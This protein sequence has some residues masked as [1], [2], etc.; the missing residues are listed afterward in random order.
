MEPYSHIGLRG[1]VVALFLGYLLTGT[2][3]TKNLKQKRGKKK[4]KGKEKCIDVII[5]Y[6]YLTRE[7]VGRRW[8]L[9]DILWTPENSIV[10]EIFGGIKP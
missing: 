2:S 8:N 4:K 6:E 9:H 1:N 7:F 10:M 5:N 3:S